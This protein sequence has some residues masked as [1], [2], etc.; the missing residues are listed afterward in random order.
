[1]LQL[2]IDKHDEM[3]QRTPISPPLGRDKHRFLGPRSAGDGSD[4]PDAPVSEGIHDKA[5]E[6]EGTGQDDDDV[7]LY[8]A[9][10]GVLSEAMLNQQSSILDENVQT[11]LRI[12]I[13][14]LID[15]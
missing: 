9:V 15:K 11:V 5:Q 4:A 14:T 1:M 6:R 12:V 13:G 2:L 3:T 8:Q 7:E 10:Y